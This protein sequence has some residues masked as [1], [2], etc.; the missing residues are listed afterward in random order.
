MSD[1][2]SPMNLRPSDPALLPLWERLL[3]LI[4]AQG[5]SLVAFSGG[6][7]SSLLLAAAQA[8]LGP[9]VSAVLCLGPFTPPW[10][11]KRARQTAASLGVE[12]IE[13]RADE[14]SLFPVL[15]NAPDRCYYCKRR[16]LE[17]MLDLAQEMGQRAVLEGS[18]ADDDPGQRPGARAVEELGV[19]SPLREA[20]LG[21]AQ[22]QALGQD[23]GLE[24][25]LAP[26]GACLAT[27][28]APGVRLS[29]SALARVARAEQ[30]VR[31]IIP[32]QVRVRDHF[33]L[34]RLELD[35]SAIEEMASPLQ[36]R[37]L[38]TVLRE[39]G[40]QRAALDLAGYI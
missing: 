40:Y 15:H 8:A 26:S 7:D 21:K 1:A 17:M 33:P 35:P 24:A 20:G 6:A 23:L 4:K 30:A 34:A 12:L 2:V 19:G 14:L 25:A 16:R 38:L 32:G 28:F 18:Q 29:P 13:V 10:E 5:P 3:A 9:A 31:E 22:I 11:E 39:A 27:R 36:R 37:R